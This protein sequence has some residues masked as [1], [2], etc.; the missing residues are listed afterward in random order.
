MKG[1]E[2][3]E[4]CHSNGPYNNGH[5]PRTA[6]PSL[7]LED[8][9]KQDLFHWY[10]EAIT[11][12]DDSEQGQSYLISHYNAGNLEGACTLC[13]GATLAGGVGPACTGCH[14]MDPVPN[15]ARCVSCHGWPPVGSP[16]DLIEEVGREEE[17]YN[18][19]VYRT[20]TQEVAKGFHLQHDTIPSEDRETTEDCRSCHGETENVDNHHLFV[21]KRIP[22]DTDAPFGEPG[23]VYVC[24]TCHEVVLNPITHEF[25][26]KVVRDCN[27]CHTDEFPN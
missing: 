1:C 6:H 7:D 5:N 23:E 2:S 26:F 12:E 17:L 13:H 25:E 14:V 19:P 3:T 10:G 24:L 11:F 15:P 9:S 27:A 22:D 21:G 8:P 18:N 20:F 4:G 16:A